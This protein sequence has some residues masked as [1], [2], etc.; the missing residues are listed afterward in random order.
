MSL[1]RCCK[2]LWDTS[3][4]ARELNSNSLWWK[5]RQMEFYSN[6]RTRSLNR[7]GIQCHQ[8][9]V[10]SCELMLLTAHDSHPDGRHV[11]RLNEMQKSSRF[12]SFKISDSMYNSHFESLGM[13]DSL[14][15]PL[16]ISLM[17]LFLILSDCSLVISSTSLGNICQWKKSL[18][19]YAALCITE[20]QLQQYCTQSYIFKGSPRC[21]LKEFC[22]VLYS[23]WGYWKTGWGG[24]EWERGERGRGGR[25]GNAP[26]G[27][28]CILRPTCSL[29]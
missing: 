8:V 18:A 12:S 5:T 1:E 19:S 29:A 28:V 7:K 14:I 10:H 17:G 15:V 13:H 25:T 21:P 4:F 26:S 22:C 23:H 11:R 2:A 20:T 16:G 6:W 3:N 9:Y 24:W 27:S